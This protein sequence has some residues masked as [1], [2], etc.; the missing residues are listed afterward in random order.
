MATKAQIDQILDVR[1]LPLPAEP[2]VVDLKYETYVDSIGDDALRIWVILE[3]DTPSE[4]RSW[5]KVAPIEEA[6]HEALLKE[7]V[8]LWPYVDFR[9]RIE[10][11]DEFRDS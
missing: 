1:K 2:R 6:I 10:F 4:Q 9:T 5:A 7:D 8:R 11:E 3:D